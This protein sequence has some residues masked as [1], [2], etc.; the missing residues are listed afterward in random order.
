ML[1]KKSFTYSYI[2]NS[3]R[4]IS[5]LQN[6]MIFYRGRQFCMGRQDKISA[7]GRTRADQYVLSL[8]PFKSQNDIN[9]H[10]PTKLNISGVHLSGFINLSL[11]LIKW[12]KIVPSNLRLLEKVNEISRSQWSKSW[13]VIT[14]N[15]QT[16]LNPCSCI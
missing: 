2:F 8:D 3:V 10:S 1:I 5:N 9:N 6:V 16:W 14:Q 13:P 4:H 15:V 11:K 12:E 7:S